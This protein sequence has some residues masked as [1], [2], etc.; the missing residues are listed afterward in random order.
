MMFL[1]MLLRAVLA[2]L[3]AVL[4]QLRGSHAI[5]W[6]GYRGFA[7]LKHA[8][9]WDLALLHGSLL[10]IHTFKPPTSYDH[11]RLNSFLDFMKSSLSLEF[12]HMPVNGIW[13]SHL[14]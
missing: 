6:L 2:L 1:G 9:A 14:Y 10:L 12:S 4:A 7:S 5:V 8:I 13:C 11:T 3:H